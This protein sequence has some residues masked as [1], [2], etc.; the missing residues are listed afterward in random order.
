MKIYEKLD[1]IDFLNT[2][3]KLKLKAVIHM[4][5]TSDIYI[6][7]THGKL[8]GIKPTDSP[9]QW[10]T[11]K[12]YDSNEIDDLLLKSYECYKL[13]EELTLKHNYTSSPSHSTLDS[14]FFNFDHTRY[15][16]AYKLALIP[17]DKLKS[18]LTDKCNI[19]E[20]YEYLF[21]EKSI[22]L[23]EAIKKAEIERKIEIAKLRAIQEIEIAKIN[24]ERKLR[25][26]DEGR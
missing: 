21:N 20:M 14:N 18:L 25:E 3:Y 24:A 11:Y 23:D 15:L 2:Q 22:S 7:E 12:V 6:I 1:S 17:N 4:L 26:K 16:T 10:D 8:Y 19:K 13:N 9:T 5:Q